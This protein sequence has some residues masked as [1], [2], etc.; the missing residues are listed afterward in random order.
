MDTPAPAS[1][2]TS[3]TPSVPSEAETVV[4]T[5]AQT[6]P[7]PLPKL[8]SGY[9]KLAREQRAAKEASAKLES[10]RK[11]FE[12]EQKS[13]TQRLV[14]YEAAKAEAKRNPLRWLEQN[15]LTYQDLV[16]S[17]LNDGKP[18]ANLEVKAVRD[19]ISALKADAEAREKKATEERA[20]HSKAQEEQVLNRFRA[21]CAAHVTAAGEKFELLNLYNAQSRVAELIEAHY[22]QQVS[23]GV[24]E[25]KILSFDEAAEE[26]ESALEIEAQKVIKSKKLQ[27]YLQPVVVPSL[28]KI[29]FDKP[30]TLSLSNKL[31]TSTTPSSNEKLTRQQREEKALAALARHAN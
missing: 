17:Q 18:T 13:A 19:E 6:T 12:A 31:T 16:E 23:E 7:P 26:I 22:S 27:K 5:T 8:S 24:K 2:D 14:D 15:G 10:D 1:T 21:E 25:P 28:K 4:A 29:T 3:V 11:A 20:A 30:K 9:A